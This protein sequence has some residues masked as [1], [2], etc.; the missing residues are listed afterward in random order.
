[1]IV[2]SPSVINDHENSI[3]RVSFSSTG[4]IYFDPQ[5]STS[6]M[7]SS[8]SILSKYNYDRDVV[9]SPILESEPESKSELLKNGTRV[10]LESKSRVHVL[11]L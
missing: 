4:F 5:D 6:I 7:T 10:R 8:A 2:V 3:N 9:E 11:Q 1:M